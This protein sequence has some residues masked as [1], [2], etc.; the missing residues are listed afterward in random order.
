MQDALNFD[1]LQDINYMSFKMLHSMLNRF[2]MGGFI[3]VVCMFVKMLCLSYKDLNINVTCCEHHSANMYKKRK[4]LF[5]KSVMQFKDINSKVSCKDFSL[6][7][8]ASRPR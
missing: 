8:L 6:I 3:F 1:V 2:P 5:N 4:K 7:D